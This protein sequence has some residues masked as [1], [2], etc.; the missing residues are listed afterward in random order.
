MTYKRFM[1]L[2]DEYDIRLMDVHYEWFQS[3][4]EA[5]YFILLVKKNCIELSEKECHEFCELKVKLKK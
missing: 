4:D 3:D 2:Q 1:E 5:R